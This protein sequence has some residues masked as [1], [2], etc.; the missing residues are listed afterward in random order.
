MQPT[1]LTG[2]PPGSHA[3]SGNSLSGPARM[4]AGSVVIAAICAA[5]LS[6]DN[7]ATAISKGPNQRA[8]PNTCLATKVIGRLSPAAEADFHSSMVSRRLTAPAV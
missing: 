6:G 1:T 8:D 4:F 3:T 5:A 7:V 2:V